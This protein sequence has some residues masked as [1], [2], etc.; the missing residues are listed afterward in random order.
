MVETEF[1][2]QDQDPGTEFS[3]KRRDSPFQSMTSNLWSEADAAWM[4]RG[5]IFEVERKYRA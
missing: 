2:V 3:S 5:L 1:R 4:L